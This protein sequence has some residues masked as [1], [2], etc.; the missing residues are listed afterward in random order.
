MSTKILAPAILLITR[1][2]IAH[3]TSVRKLFTTFVIPIMSVV[4]AFTVGG[5]E[6]LGLLAEQFHLMGRIWN[7][8][9]LST[10]TSVCSATGSRLS[11]Q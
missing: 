11:L 4:I 5:I 6:A 10:R 1:R 2:K 8:V 3:G 7:L 9:T